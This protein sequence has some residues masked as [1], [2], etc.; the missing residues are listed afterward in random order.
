M[1]SNDT[2]VKNQLAEISGSEDH[3]I[4]IER[5][6]KV[7]ESISPTTTYSYG[8]SCGVYFC[9]YCA[10]NGLEHSPDPEGDERNT[11]IRYIES[12]G[13]MAVLE[14]MITFQMRLLS[15]LVPAILLLV[16]RIYIAALF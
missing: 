3:V 4:D 6:T 11:W 14:S 13:S 1:L 7:Q 10:Q 2:P 9:D 5:I 8:S 16:L 12:E 15:V